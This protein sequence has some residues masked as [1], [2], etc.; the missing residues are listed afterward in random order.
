MIFLIRSMEVQR[1][2]LGAKLNKRGKSKLSA[3]RYA[4]IHS[5]SVLDGGY[6]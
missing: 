6:D 5:L 4:Y 2:I 1:P 3:S